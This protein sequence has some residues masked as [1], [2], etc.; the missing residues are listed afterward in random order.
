MENKKIICFYFL[1]F[2]FFSCEKSYKNLGNDLYQH[3]NK[4]YILQKGI[5]C[6]AKTCDTLEHYD[7][8][9]FYKDRKDWLS[10]NEFIDIPTFKKI[11]K[12]YYYDKNY[13][14]IYNNFPGCF[15]SLNVIKCK[16]KKV[17]F[18]GD[19]YYLIDNKIFSRSK[20]LKNVDVKTFIV[21]DVSKDGEC[22]AKDNKNYFLED[23]IVSEEYFNE[24]KNAIRE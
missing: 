15:P 4:L 23:S 16:N 5:L 10:I 11:N 1:F 2:I 20:E 9:C 14:Y 3:N 6:D 18:L 7:S 12:K 13:V 24:V 19:E 21:T 17:K 22:F 8:L